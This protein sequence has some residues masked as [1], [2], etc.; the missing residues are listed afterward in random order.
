[1]REKGSRSDFQG[2]SLLEAFLLLECSVKPAEEDPFFFPFF[3]SK[4]RKGLSPDS[5][6]R[7]FPSGSSSF[8]RQDDHPLTLDVWGYF[9]MVQFFS[10]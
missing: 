7:N 10:S 6:R 3:S 8:S 1:M 2:K 9:S 5:F 4:G